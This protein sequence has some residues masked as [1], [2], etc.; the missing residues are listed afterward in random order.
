MTDLAMREVFAG[1]YEEDQVLQG[2]SLAAHAGKISAVLGP[3]GSGKSTALRVLAGLVAP[4]D[5]A[6]I[7]DDSEITTVPA[8][9][10]IDRGIG[11]LPQG[12]S[13]FPSLTILENIEMGGWIYRR[14]RGQRRQAISLALERYPMLR[15][16]HGEPAGTLSGGQQRLVE[17]A[18]ML[19]S[20]PSVVL[21]DEPG[22]GLAP[23]L[24][25][26]V[27]HEIRR[28]RDEGRAVLLVDQNVK[29][30]V[31]IA[32]YIYTLELGANSQEGSRELFMDDLD[33][34]VRQWLELG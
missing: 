8:Y 28:L 7:I 4:R 11:F 2:V 15:E 19:V 34:V 16:R 24:A 9:E 17:I 31:E 10:R 13:V 32:D 12:R 3:N 6:V 29:Q 33:G 30:A 23:A 25:A 14:N 1:Y 20:D 22:A 5:G 18:R 27:Y 26:D 21:I